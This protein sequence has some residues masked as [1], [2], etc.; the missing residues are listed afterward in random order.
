ME[1]P[2]TATEQPLL[3]KLSKEEQTTGSMVEKTSYSIH[4]KVN[5]NVGWFGIVRSVKENND[6][7]EL[8]VEMRYFDGLTD[9]HLQIV[10]FKGGGDFKVILPGTGH[11]I[12]RLCLVRAYGTVVEEKDQIPAVDAQYVR[13]WP[14]GQ[15]SFMDYG[16]DKSNPQWKK[17][18]TINPDDV[19]SSNPNQAYY[20][21]C[22][23]KRDDEK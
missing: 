2:P 21:A 16:E 6:I 12:D 1:Y 8:L 5:K 17:L 14:W 4:E 20:E 13:V 11:H 15:F 7:T 9:L 23:G 10:S 19:Y 22:L 18:R 3:K